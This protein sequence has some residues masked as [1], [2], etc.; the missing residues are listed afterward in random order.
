VRTSK[1]RVQRAVMLALTVDAHAPRSPTTSGSP[2]NRI[3]IFDEGQ[4]V[5]DTAVA[6]T[7]PSAQLLYNEPRAH[8]VDD[9]SEDMLHASLLG[10]RGLD[11]GLDSWHKEHNRSRREAIRALASAPA[12]E[13]VADVLVYGEPDIMTEHDR[14]VTNVHS[15]IDHMDEEI[16]VDVL[17]LDERFPIFSKGFNSKTTVGISFKNMMVEDTVVGGPASL[18]GKIHVGDVLVQVDGTPATLENKHDLLLGDD[19]PGTKVVL[20]LQDKSWHSELQT[21][22]LKQYKEVTLTR[23]ST[24]HIADRRRMAELFSAIREQ[25]DRFGDEELSYQLDQCQK[26]HR[27]MQEAEHVHF[28][29]V[30]ENCCIRQGG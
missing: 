17:A 27:K 22:A 28:G 11:S 15:I 3:R 29:H 23:M 18:S 26:L 13:T 5:Q 7:T 12:M 9:G 30:R 6:V 24:G 10:T 2:Q 20:K 19:V 4:P 1:A 21:L 8:H 14:L 25:V 16:E